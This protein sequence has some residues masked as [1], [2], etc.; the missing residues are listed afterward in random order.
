MYSDYFDEFHEPYV[1]F[2][3]DADEYEAQH[4][5]RSITC[6]FCG[7][8]NL[9][10]KY[11]G[12][13]RLHNS[14]GIHICKLKPILVSSSWSEAVEKAKTLR[15]ASIVPTFIDNIKKYCVYNTTH[16]D[17]PFTRI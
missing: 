13:W 9:V 12:Q 8:R 10:W 2:G 6:K 16:R 1:G 5:S 17:R 15:S 14:N 4:E 11:N 3:D 7:A